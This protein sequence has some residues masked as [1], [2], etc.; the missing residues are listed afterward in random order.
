MMR[1]LVLA[2]MAC[3]CFTLSAQP[4]P[5]LPHREGGLIVQLAE[6]ISFPDFAAAF[7]QTH[8]QLPVPLRRRALAPEHGFYL[9][10]VPPGSEQRLIA[11]LQQMPQ[12][13]FAQLDYELQVRT[14]TPNDP[15]YAQQWALEAIGAPQVWDLSTGG[16]TPSQHQIVIGVVDG[17]FDIWHED[18]LANIWVNPHEI[19]DDQIDNDDNGYVDDRYGWNFITDSPEHQVDNSLPNP[20]HGNNVCGVIGAEGNNALGVAGLN[21]QVKILPMEGR[22][23]SEIVEAFAYAAALRTRYNDSGGTAGAF[24][25]AVNGSLGIDR[26]WCEELPA[27]QAMYDVLGQAGIL[28]VAATS[29]DSLDVDEKGDMPTTCPSEFLIT[30]TASDEYDRHVKSGYGATSI[31]LA[32][33]GRNIATTANDNA[34][35]TGQGGTSMAAPFVAGA[36]G[37]LYAMPSPQLETLALQDPPAAARLVRDA[38]LETVAPV[39][40]LEGKSVTGGRLDLWQAMRYLHAWTIARQDERQSGDFFFQYTGFEGVLRVWPNPYAGGEL[41]IAYATSSF[42]PVLLYVYDMQGRLMYRKEQTPIPF[43]PQTIRIPEAADW[44]PGVYVAALKS[45]IHPPITRRIVKT[46]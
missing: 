20:N 28:S 27:W 38:L 21:W 5:E 24:V 18:L 26:V 15:L 23:V 7:R 35:S 14:T 45:Q 11:A 33:P 3:A 44:P 41:H 1:L 19:P 16:V 31:D 6:G 36:I 2:C 43:E 29:N 39:P 17:G 34:Y 32:A 40:N 12:V 9:V 42:Q 46:P 4:R 25:V 10:A 30:V 37:L 13:H 22:Y 8:P